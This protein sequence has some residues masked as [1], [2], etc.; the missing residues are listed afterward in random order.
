MSGKAA[1][2]PAGDSAYDAR[3]D[4]AGGGQ[5]SAPGVTLN[6]ESDRFAAPSLASLTRKPAISDEGADA[7]LTPPEPPKIALPPMVRPQSEEMPPVPEP[8]RLRVAPDRAKV[9]ESRGGTSESEAAVKAAL[10][11]L[12]DN[13]SADGRWDPRTHEAGRETNVL[14]QNRQGAGG[15][16]DTAMTGLALLAFLAS[17]HTHVEGLYRDEVRRGLEFLMR[18]QAADGGLAGQSVLFESMYCHAMAACALSEAYGMTHDERLR[19]PVRRAIAYTV[20]AQ[21]SRGG[22]WR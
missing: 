6:A 9:A 7:K 19:E 18:S 8:Y 17:G 16:A 2:S 21:D 20:A 12:A 3:D 13:Q 1:G 14:G 11:W 5:S 22:G 15:R 10:K 4:V